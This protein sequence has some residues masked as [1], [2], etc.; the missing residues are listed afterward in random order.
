MVPQTS[1]LSYN[2]QEMFSKKEGL[3]SHQSSINPGVKGQGYTRGGEKELLHKVLPPKGSGCIREE[4]DSSHLSGGS[5]G[6]SQQESP[7]PGSALG[8]L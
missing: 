6:R 4:T 2:N 8:D 1:F 7:P 3:K 5:D